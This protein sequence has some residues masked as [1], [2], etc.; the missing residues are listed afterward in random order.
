MATL[1]RR[2]FLAAVGA[3]A[4]APRVFDAASREAYAV[5]VKTLTY[6]SPGGKDLVLDLYLPQGP[7]TPAD[8][9]IRARRWLVG[10]HNHHRAGPQAIF[11]AR[12]FRNGVN[13]VSTHA[14]HNVSKQRRRRENCHSLASSQRRSVS[15]ES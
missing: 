10:R 3:F 9:C 5:N 13:R 1:D 6:A 4:L 14:I 7:G 12:R 2:T 15:F 8:H 11:R